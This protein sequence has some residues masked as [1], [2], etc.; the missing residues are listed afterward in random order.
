MGVIRYCYKNPLKIERGYG[1]LR[2]PLF[3]YVAVPGGFE[4]PFSP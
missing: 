3:S 4:P 1:F 2:N